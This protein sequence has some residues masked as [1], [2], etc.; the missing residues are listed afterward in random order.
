MTYGIY[1]EQF[2]PQYKLVEKMGY[3]EIFLRALPEVSKKYPIRYISKD[4]KELICAQNLMLEYGFK[5]I[6]FHER[7]LNGIAPMKTGYNVYAEQIVFL[8]NA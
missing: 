5:Q 1:G 8:Q 3:F 7:P 6:H 2:G 4:E